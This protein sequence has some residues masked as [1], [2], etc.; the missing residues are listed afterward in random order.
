MLIPNAAALW[1]TMPNI[2]QDVLANYTKWHGMPNVET[3]HKMGKIVSKLQSE[4][5]KNCQLPTAKNLDTLTHAAIQYLILSSSASCAFSKK[6][7]PADHYPPH[8]HR[9]SNIVC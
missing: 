8:S 1:R 3:Q 4:P 5:L 7:K 9:Y 6:R 2:L